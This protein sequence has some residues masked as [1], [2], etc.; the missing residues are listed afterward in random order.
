MLKNVISLDIG[1]SSI[2]SAV[3]NSNN[4]IIENTYEVISLDSS[5]DKEYILNKF[6]EPITS[7]IN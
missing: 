5:R 7:K 4:H 6:I 3:I 1:G 2:K